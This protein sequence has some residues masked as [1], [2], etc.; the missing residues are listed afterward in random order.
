MDTDNNARALEIAQICEFMREGGPTRAG[1][2]VA[3]LLKANEE[4]TYFKVK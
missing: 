4:V 1:K 3:T 2:T